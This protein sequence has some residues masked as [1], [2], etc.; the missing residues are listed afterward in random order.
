MGIAKMKLINISGDIDNLNDVLARFSNLDYFHPELASKMIDQVH[1]SS[2]LEENREIHDEYVKFQEMAHVLETNTEQKVKINER[3]YQATLNKVNEA[4]EK[5]KEANT[6]LREIQEVIQE[7]EDALVL[8]N[9]IHSMD[10]SFDEL[11][12]CNYV[13][14]RFGRLPLDSVKKLT[15]YESHPF[16][17]QSLVE[18][19]TYCWCFYLTST[20]FEV[21]VDNIFSS[22][23]FER[24]F[25]P[26]FIHGTPDEAIITLQNEMVEDKKHLALIEGVIEKYKAE[27]ALE[28]AGLKEYYEMI[29]NSMEAR[30]YVLVLGERFV[31]TGFSD[32]KDVS[33]LESSFDGVEVEID[34][35]PAYSDK[36]LTPPTKITN[37]WFVRPFGMYVEMYGVPEYAGIDPTPIVA[38]TYSLLFGMM[39]GDVGQGIVLIL[40]GLFAAKKWKMR[41]GEIGVRIGIF[42]TIFGFVYGSVF[43]NE[44]LLDP[45]FHALGFEE[46]PIEIMSADFIPLLLVSAVGIGAVLIVFSMLV[47]IGL[48]IKNKNYNELI[49]SQNGISGLVFYVSVLVGA[50]CQVVLQIP[51]LSN[52]LFLIVC[53]I[54]PLVLMFL[55]EALHH[56]SHHQPMF[57]QGFGSYFIESFFEL[58]EIVLS[59]ITNTISYLRV[60]GFVLSHA[61]MM[62]AVTLI[63]DMAG[64]GAWIAM[65]L[66]NIIVMVI[67]GMIVG[68]Q[69]LRLEFYEMFS[70]YFNGNGIAFKAMKE[71]K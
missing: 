38:I 62:M 5:V 32:E 46:K 69:V 15:Y 58:F 21:D 71:E 9:N 3:N 65:I 7:N 19:D 51:L 57:P 52:K 40:V 22:L 42:S 39:F 45:M 33:K 56:R 6:F 16:L 60:G 26:S 54:I 35:R 59:Y 12:E 29:H 4:Y 66:G 8:M 27:V 44:H 36:R 20:K 70:R 53:I 11:F 34:I 2:V 49:F 23:Y 64:S 47:N 41:L 31:I 13:K 17:F 68:I 18:D 1:G 63:A 25:I 48:Q 10:L 28:V 67:E 37:N 24:V 55:K 43:G 50:I 30:K 61:G 14:F